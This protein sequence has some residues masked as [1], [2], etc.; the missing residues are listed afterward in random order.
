VQ[1]SETSYG[2]EILMLKKI[3]LSTAIAATLFLA[4]CGGGGSSDSSTGG[5]SSSEPR[6]AVTGPLTPVQSTLSTSVLQ[7][8][9]V[10]TAGTPLA[11]HSTS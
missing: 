2:K 10:A 3:G 9:V 5:P 7:P 6:S 4:A 1:R 8:L 11:T